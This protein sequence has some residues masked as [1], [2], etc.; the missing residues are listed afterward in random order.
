MEKESR[1]MEEGKIRRKPVV[2]PKTE[3]ILGQMG[4]QIRLARLRRKISVEMVAER[5]GISRASVWSVEKGS[6]S[7]SM[8]IYAKVLAAIG[9]QDDL[10][11]IC[12]D[13]ILGRTLQDQELERHSR[14]RKTKT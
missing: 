9:M 4:T 11:K 2:M 5:A 7:V 13:D 8:G 14:G 10:K 12:G 1:I 6:P 3:R